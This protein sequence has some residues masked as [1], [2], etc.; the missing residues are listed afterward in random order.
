MKKLFSLIAL[1]GVFAACQPEELRTVFES[2]PAQL[3]IK[4]GRV[5]NAVDGN[6]L[7]AKATKDA[8][9]VITGTPAIAKGSQVMHASYGGATGSITVDYPAIV[10]DTDPVTITAGDIWIPGTIKDYVI[11]VREGAKKEDTEE[12][13]LLSAENHGI[14]HNDSKWLENA[15]EYVLVDTY[16][17]KEYT[18]SKFVDGSEKV[19]DNFFSEEIAPI[20]AAAKTG[21]ITFVEKEGTVKV[22]AWAL[23]NV[24]NK[25]TTTTTTMEIVATPTPAGAAPIPGNNGVIATYDVES[26]VAVPE[27]VEIAHPSHASHYVEPVGHEEATGTGVHHGTHGEG[28]NAGGGFVEAE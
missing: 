15:N 27:K 5:F 11:S 16:T 17:Y 9:V 21:E 12:F 13:G 19:I 2:A 1:V 3:T 6:E 7:T 26:V 28:A 24:I 20:V 10:A 14:S 18:G 25:V 22:S 4:V 23:Y 8:D